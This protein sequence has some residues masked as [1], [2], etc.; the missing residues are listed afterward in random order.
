MRCI[1]LISHRDRGVGQS[2]YR[3]SNTLRTTQGHD[4]AVILD[5]RQG[6]VLRL[7]VSGALVFQLLQHGR[8]EPEIAT[9]M[10]QQFGISQDVALADLND[11]LRSME[12]VGLVH[13]DP[14]TCIHDTT[15]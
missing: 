2:M 3:I 15:E 7:N 8:T 4:G 9:E 13:G 1:H 14:P 5:I 12:R 6:K 10:S 11:F